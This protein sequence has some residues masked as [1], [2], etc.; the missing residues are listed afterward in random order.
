MRD[1]V[2][3]HITISSA[4]LINVT[5]E[6]AWRNKAL[7][8]FDQGYRE[9]KYIASIIYNHVTECWVQDGEDPEEKLARWISHR[10][11]VEHANGQLSHV[12]THEPSK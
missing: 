9:T 7:E 4:L 12:R 10:R 11:H 2:G 5:V 1:A 6:C 8:A 3:P